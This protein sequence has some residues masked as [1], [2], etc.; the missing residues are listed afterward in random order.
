MHVRVG[1]PPGFEPIPQVV[2]RAA[3]IAMGAGGSV[4]V[5]HDPIEASR[6]AD[7]LYTDVWASIGQEAE[8]DERALVFPAYA[9]DAEKVAVA[10]P[11]V[12]VMHPLPAHRGQEISDEVI[13]GPHSVVW[14]QAENRL[15]TQAA[16]LAHVL[17]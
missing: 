9:L 2:Q 3:D 10:R 16:L 1:T 17:A 11:D 7:V 6:E 8:A 12:T 14:D 13:D 5:T 15:H 4:S